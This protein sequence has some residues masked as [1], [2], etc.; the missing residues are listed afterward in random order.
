MKQSI[1]GTTEYVII[2]DHS[3]ALVP[4]KIDTG[5]DSSAIW[6][7]HITL[8]DGTLSYSLF[9]KGSSLYTNEMRKTTRFRVVS[10]RNSFGHEELRYKI[11]LKIKIGNKTLTSWFTLA[12]RSRNMFPMLLGKSF[13]KHSFVVDVSRHFVHGNENAERKVLVVTAKPTEML[14]F[15]DD[16]KAK[17]DAKVTYQATRFEDI[18]F[19]IAGPQTSVYNLADGGQTLA[20]YDLIYVKSHW[21]HPELAG[22]LA[23]YLVF[24]NRPFFDQEIKSYASRSKLTELMKLSTN[25]LAVPRSFVAYPSV[26]TSQ[27][28]KI[29]STLG[30]PLVLKSATADQGRDNYLVT[31]AKTYASLLKKSN[32]KTL[33]IAQRYIRN[34]GFYRVNIFGKEVGLVIYRSAHPHSDPLKQHLNK[35]KGG[36]NA[37]LVPV[38]SLSADVS[39]LALKAAVCM[40]R[41]IAGV[42]IIQDTV[43]KEW[44]ILEVNNAPQIRSGPYKDEKAEAF[45]RFIDKEIER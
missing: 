43:S 11:P 32:P 21:Q 6:A 40:Q 9:D 1:I 8:E 22:A 38:S 14:S 39:E 17:N 44:Y 4:A 29:H 42:D 35:P 10:V 20:D 45:A 24:K 15:L 5:A 13:L 2:P 31:D 7:S 41:Q 25:G 16:V 3:Q 12:D 28:Q 19:E 30:F 34:E 23:E 26:L 18:L 33:L 27:A 37:E 36:V